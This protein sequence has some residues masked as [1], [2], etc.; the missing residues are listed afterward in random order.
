V[1]KHRSGHLASQ[2]GLGITPSPVVDSASVGKTPV[3]AERPV[4]GKRS[5]CLSVVSA[6]VAEEQRPCQ[7]ITPRPG[8][9]YWTYW[10]RPIRAARRQVR[11]RCRVPPRYVL[12]EDDVSPLFRYL[13][14]SP[15]PMPGDL[16]LFGAGLL[17]VLIVYLG[18]A[19]ATALLHRDRSRRLM[20][21][22]IFRDLLGVFS[23]RQR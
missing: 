2:N 11:H 8:F 21:L 23:R 12:R 4:S 10:G 3:L 13:L 17:G 15:G 20:A 14:D 22:A 1:A 19:M 7:F 9:S 6:G 5:G 18:V 16:A